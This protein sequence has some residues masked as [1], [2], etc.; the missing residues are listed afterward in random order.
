[1]SWCAPVAWDAGIETRFF[2][3]EEPND[4]PFDLG[5]LQRVL[6]LSDDITEENE[7]E[8]WAWA[9]VRDAEAYGYIGRPQR[10]IPLGPWQMVLSQFPSHGRLPLPVA[11][12]VSITSVSYFDSGGDAQE[13][14]TSPAGFVLLPNGPFTA[15]ELRP[16]AGER[17]PATACRPDAVTVTF[18]AGY[19]DGDAPAFQHVLAGIALFVGEMYRQRSLATDVRIVSSALKLE[20]FWSGP[21]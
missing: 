9:A 12:V 8:S 6:R 21:F 2:R 3:A 4:L 17:F 7:L 16:L 14:A 19:A 20:R 10:A 13:L 11:P 18:Q 15:A 1:M 5:H